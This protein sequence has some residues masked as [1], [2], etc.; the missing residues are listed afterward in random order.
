M[1]IAAVLAH[2]P[3][4]VGSH[5]EY[6]RRRSSFD[7]RDAH[8]SSLGPRSQGGWRTRR[9]SGGRGRRSGLLRTGAAWIKRSS[10]GRDEET[11]ENRAKVS[12]WNDGEASSRSRFGRQMSGGEKDETFDLVQDEANDAISQFTRRR[13]T[14]G[15][16]KGRHAGEGK[17]ETEKELED[18]RSTNSN[19]SERRY[20]ER[21]SPDISDQ[22]STKASADHTSKPSGGGPSKKLRSHDGNRKG[23][24]RT[25][26]GDILKQDEDGFAHEEQEDNFGAKHGNGNDDRGWKG[27]KARN[28]VHLEPR[29]PHDGPEGSGMNVDLFIFHCYLAAEAALS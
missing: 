22:R 7:R 26:E 20:D 25:Q 21:H 1:C 6:G 5:F 19:V 2:A 15:M 28:A 11:V 13:G 9:D 12:R 8:K 29:L 16:G 24:P 18:M 4:F 10:E 17:D 3:R 23:A 27:Y 14:G